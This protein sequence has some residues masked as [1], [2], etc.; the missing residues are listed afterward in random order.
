[1][2]DFKALSVSECAA[3]L[4]SL[5]N[6]IIVSHVR[7]DG[8]AVGSAAALTLALLSLGK[9]A[10]LLM[11]DGI[12]DRLRFIT[13]N[14]PQATADTSGDIVTVDVASRTQ[15]GSLSELDVRLSADHHARSTPFAD[16]LTLPEASSAAEVLYLVLSEMEK[17]SDF[18]INKEI[19]A[20]LYAGI[21][22]DTGGF[23]YS[24]ASA[25]THRK[26]AALIEYG[27]DFADINHRLFNSKTV[28]QLRAEGFISSNLKTEL[29][30]K[31]AYA[32]HTRNDR[33]SL[34]LSMSDFD[35]AIDIARSLIGAE[36]AILVRENDDGSLR[37]SLRSTGFNVADIAAAFG[38]G[39]HVRAAACNISA[40]STQGAAEIII[41]K[42]KLSLVGE[43]EQI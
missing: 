1:M 24:N 35:T 33:L 9:P 40:E 3:A 11:P 13:K 14:V 31:I 23:I 2:S 29:N 12:P 26:A 43:G 17:I 8:D 25:K 30:G 38:G 27:I 36:I 15:L 39:G 10:R 41:E 28:G 7:P 19:A 34:G 42:I 32:V 4:L 20:A 5:E 16:N 18:R 21:S 22:S 37:A 6:P